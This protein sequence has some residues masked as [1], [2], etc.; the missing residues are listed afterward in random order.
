[1][2]RKEKEE[3]KKEG[4]QKRRI[5]EKQGDMKPVIA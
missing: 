5:D 2:S 4:L 3:R 1:L